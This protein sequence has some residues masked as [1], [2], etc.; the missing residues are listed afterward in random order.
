MISE[1]DIPARKQQLRQQCVRRRRDQLDPQ[2][3]SRRIV[4]RLRQLPEYR[5][6]RTISTYVSMPHEVQTLSLLEQ[7]WDEGKQVVVP[8]CVAK[9]LELFHVRSID[10]LAPRTLGIL[11]PR[12]DFR[13]QPD[14]W[15]SAAQID[16]FV[17]PGLAFDR[18]GRR[19]GYGKGYY[20]RLLAGA[21]EVVPRVA[22]AFECQLVEQV[23]VTASDIAM[24]CVITEE[25]VYRCEEDVS[26]KS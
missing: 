15:L 10:D 18:H 25:N 7:A 19:L 6:A 11:E 2:T 17:I 24:H 14:R 16:L 21:P 22:L 5:E 4:S 3:A 12:A 23:P 1:H 8:C 20:D 9:R 26:R 13:Q